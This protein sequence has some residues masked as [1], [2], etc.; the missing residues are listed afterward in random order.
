NFDNN[1]TSLYKVDL[2]KENTEHIPTFIKLDG[3]IKKE[4]LQNILNPTNIKSRVMSFS[5]QIMSMLGNIYPIS[6][7][8]I[9]KYIQRILADFG[10]DEFV[11][12]SNN[13]YSYTSK[14]KEKIKVLTENYAAQIFKEYID[15]DKIII[16]N[17]YNL[18]DNIKLVETGK[19]IT[20]SLYEKESK[21]N[22]F[23]ERIIN[24]IANMPNILCWT[25]NIEKRGYKINGFINHYPDFIIQTN[26]GKTILLETKGDHLEAEQKIKLGKYWGEK[27]G[28]DYRY[29]MVYEKR[30]VKDAYNEE[31]I[32]NII[33][34]L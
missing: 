26:A 25:K 2:D 24:E 14:I 29:F 11:N 34:A 12:L 4:V 17:T 27:A 22:G 32:L 33:K 6:D 31:N 23:E 28:N 16:K 9:S 7:N 21:M 8:E 15:S 10:E 1:N 30:E 5:K 20:K 19:S 13:L 18:S 3:E